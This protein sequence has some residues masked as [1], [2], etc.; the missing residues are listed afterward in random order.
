MGSLLADAGFDTTAA[1]AVVRRARAGFVRELRGGKPLTI[2]LGGRFRKERRALESLLDPAADQ[3]SALWP[4]LVIL[5]RRSERL[6]PVM[7][8]LR[9]RERE[10]RLAIPVAD[11]AISYLHMFANRLI[12]SAAP[13]HEAVLYDFLSRLY[14]SSI[15]RSTGRSRKALAD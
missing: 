9:V 15:A 5:R 8:E 2:G 12:R 7:S 11:I 4:G 3:E 14:A 6:L 1:L 13:A 10:G